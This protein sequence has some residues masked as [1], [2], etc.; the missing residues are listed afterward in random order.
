MSLK[1]E[2]PTPEE[3]AEFAYQRLKLDI[4]EA[5]NR[6]GMC[7]IY[8][9]P[10]TQEVIDRIVNE[11]TEKGWVCNNYPKEAEQGDMAGY[12]CVR[13]IH[14]KIPRNIAIITDPEKENGADYPGRL[15]G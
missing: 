5:C 11:F 7:N 9:I 10:W 8:L 13:P 1:I 14:E 2:I 3:S 6:F 4:V 12:L 15:P